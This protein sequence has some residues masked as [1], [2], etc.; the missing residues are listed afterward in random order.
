MPS[1]KLSAITPKNIPSSKEYLR[2]IERAV[3]KTANASKRDMQST[4]RTWDHKVDFV[5]VEESGGDYSITVGTDDKIYG[6]VNDGTK[7]HVIRPKKSRFL[8]FR[9]GYRAK[10]RVGIIGSRAGGA[11]GDQVT[12][13]EVH[14]PGF[15]GRNFIAVIAKRRQ[16]TL[17]QETDQNI[18]KVARKQA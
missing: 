5:V 8:S 16:K 7:P 1:L 14:H 12:A 2:A 18:A 10:T 3:K 9:G 17:Q 11:F 6:Y 4:T 13:Q 15:P